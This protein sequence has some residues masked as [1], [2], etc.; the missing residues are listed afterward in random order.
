MKGLRGGE[1][2][3]VTLDGVF[4]KR[5]FCDDRVHIGPEALGQHLLSACAPTVHLRH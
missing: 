5:L 3:N 4:V 2:P 1:R